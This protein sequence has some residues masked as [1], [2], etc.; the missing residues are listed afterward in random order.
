MPHHI[1]PL[2]NIFENSST[3]SHH[4]IPHHLSPLKNN[5]KNSRKSLHVMSLFSIELQLIYVNSLDIHIGHIITQ[6]KLS[7]P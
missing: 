5:Y 7:A 3:T 6:S 4:L 2:K 1:S